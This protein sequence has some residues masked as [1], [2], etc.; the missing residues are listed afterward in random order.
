MIE[1]KKATYNELDF[2]C[3]VCKSTQEI[4]SDIMPGAFLKQGKKYEKFGLPLDYDI[5]IIRNDKEEIGFLG[6]TSLKEDSVYLVALYLLKEYYR[7]SYGSLT[8]SCLCKELKTK[9]VSEIVLQ[10]HIKAHWAISFY[11]KNGFE[12]ISRDEEHLKEIIIKDTIMM[13]KRF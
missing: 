13:S 4:Y 1:L 6:L 12:E 3:Q 2:V 11:K 5:H 7:Q 10:A 9:G 8:I